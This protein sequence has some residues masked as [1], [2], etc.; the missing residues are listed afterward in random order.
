MSLL[1]G[2]SDQ[3]VYR[4]ATPLRGGENKVMQE[5]IPVP[6]R[7]ESEIQGSNLVSPKYPASS[8]LPGASSRNRTHIARIKSPP[9]IHSAMLAWR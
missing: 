3:C 6:H 1:A 2:L 9:P 5:K 7:K 4:F 8:H